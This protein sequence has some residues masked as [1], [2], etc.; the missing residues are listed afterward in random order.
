MVE[1][2]NASGAP[3]KKRKATKSKRKPRSVK[4][5]LLC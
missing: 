3:P 5:T 1:L 2:L 4:V